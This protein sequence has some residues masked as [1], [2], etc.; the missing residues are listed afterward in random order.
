M[1]DADALI[2]RE[3]LIIVALKALRIET[4]GT[5]GAMSLIGVVVSNASDRAKTAALIAK[6][7]SAQ[8]IKPLVSFVRSNDDLEACVA[9][10]FFR[11]LHIR[12][13]RTMIEALM[14]LE[15]Q[16]APALLDNIDATVGEFRESRAP[17][18]RR[19]TWRTLMALTSVEPAL[20][21]P[22]LFTAGFIPHAVRMLRE[23]ADTERSQLDLLLTSRVVE[24]VANVAIHKSS[25]PPLLAGGVVEALKRVLARSVEK[26]T[27]DETEVDDPD[28]LDAIHVILSRGPVCALAYLL[29][30]EVSIFLLISPH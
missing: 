2:Q 10:D 8:L 11:R 1:I 6:I 30:R 21:H 5:L 18:V 20:V 26:A 9:T 3:S 13:D 29:G 25:R 15:A 17:A 12:H 27:E 7:V 24:T 16:L 4:P 22:R 19:L 28:W 23:I 14:G